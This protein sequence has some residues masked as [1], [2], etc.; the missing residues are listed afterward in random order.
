M[1]WMIYLI[2]NAGSFKNHLNGNS[3]KIVLSNLVVTM[4]RV[5]IFYTFRS[6]FYQTRKEKMASI[7]WCLV[8]ILISFFSEG[9]N[10]PWSLTW[11]VIYFVMLN[12]QWYFIT[13]ITLCGCGF[14]FTSV[15]RRHRIIDF[16]GK[17]RANKGKL[18]QFFHHSLNSAG[19]YYESAKYFI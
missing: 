2:I 1:L 3:Y 15:S 12:F 8:C 14:L 5:M 11:T 9:E 18:K 10:Q 6:C 13:L 19:N 16:I 7:S 4:Q 17:R